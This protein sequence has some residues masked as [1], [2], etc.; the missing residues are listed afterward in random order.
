M[1]SE[2]FKDDET[3]ETEF[4][5][6]ATITATKDLKLEKTVLPDGRYE[7]YG[8]FTD[9]YGNEYTSN[10]FVFTLEEGKVTQASVL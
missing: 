1:L 10:Y 4:W 6:T 8:L 3:L 7:T 2:K 5:E 9:F